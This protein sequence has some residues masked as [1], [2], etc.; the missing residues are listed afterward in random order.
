MPPEKGGVTRD[1]LLCRHGETAWNRERRIMGSL[2]VPL[3]D[4]GRAQCA[5][6]ARLLPAFGVTR[7]VASPLARAA[8]TADIV[9]RA[10][11][12]PVFVDADLEEVRFGRWQGM[13][14]DEIASDPLFAGY[15]ENP[16]ECA[17][18]G[19]ETAL[20]V[21]RRGLAAVERAASGER[22]LLV[23]HGDLI[24]TVLCH[25]LAIPVGQY[26]RLRVDNASLS[27]FADHAGRIE[28]KFVNLLAEPDR[29]WHRVHWERGT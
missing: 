7:I 29:A 2:D 3:S 18:P 4:A 6:L 1:I 12:L 27:A 15:V 17:T 9:A 14:Y 25:F 5:S 22:T 16:V 13:T 11:G 23:S 10:L 19:G 8:E 28:I 26:R 20:D 24:R 21:Q